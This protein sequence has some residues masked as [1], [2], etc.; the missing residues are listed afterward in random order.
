MSSLT[1]YS[2]RYKRDISVAEIVSPHD[3]KL[4]YTINQIANNEK[5]EAATIDFLKKVWHKK[6]PED[7]LTANI[8]K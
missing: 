8:R 2:S 7:K 1:F 3:M 4:Y 6:H 5:T